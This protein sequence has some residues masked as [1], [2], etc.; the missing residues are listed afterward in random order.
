MQVTVLLIADPEA[1]VSLTPVFSSIGW[2]VRVQPLGATALVSA[3]QA[4]LKQPCA[5]VQAVPQL[6]QL[7]RSAL[8]ST[9]ER[10]MA[11]LKPLV[12]AE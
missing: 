3:V 9:H 10:L 11:P 6:P 8:G 5:V 7:P 2:T 1:A 4:P 12:Q